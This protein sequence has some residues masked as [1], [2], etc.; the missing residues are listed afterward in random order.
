MPAGPA[1]AAGDTHVETVRF[2][3]PRLPEVK[4]VRGASADAAIAA[5]QPAFHPTPANSEF[6]TFG[7]GR[8]DRVRIVRGPSAAGAPVPRAGRS[9]EMV[10]FAALGAPAVS[11]VRGASAA[12]IG[13]GLFGAATGLGLFGAARGGELDRVAF[14]VDGVESGHGRNLAMWRAEFDGPQGPMQVSAAAALD[15]GGGD[16]FDTRQNRLI[17]RAFL[18]KLYQRYGN[19]PD[20]IAAYNW[21][22]GHLDQWIAAGRPAEHLPLETAHYLLRVLHDSLLPELPRL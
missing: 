17:G 6:V 5:A 13:G 7:D 11:V 8:G 22:P 2:S 4:I 1:L 9:V 21:G 15:V 14:A 19:W 10:R 18:A 12:T 20:A 16:R 3:D